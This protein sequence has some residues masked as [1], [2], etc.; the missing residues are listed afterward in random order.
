MPP[1]FGWFALWDCFEADHKV[2]RCKRQC[3]RR[4]CIR[5][6][7]AESGDHG[8]KTNKFLLC[9]GT[10]NPEFRWI[11][12]NTFKRFIFIIFSPR[13]QM[14]PLAASYSPFRICSLCVCVC[15]R[16]CVWQLTPKPRLTH[17]Q[18][19]QFSNSH[20]TLYL[21]FVWTLFFRRLRSFFSVPRVC[22]LYTSMCRI[23]QWKRPF[24]VSDGGDEV[25]VK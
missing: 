11:Y 2:V 3:R 7:V 4:W 21:E 24:C 5:K 6:L 17:F 10:I 13:L 22:T 23:S 18:F 8:R 15:V 12:T 1:P 20:V 14:N 19:L 9:S 25:Q 16:G